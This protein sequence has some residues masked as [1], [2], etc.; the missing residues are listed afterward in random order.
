MHAAVADCHQCNRWTRNRSR[1]AMH[2]FGKQFDGQAAAND[3]INNH[4]EI[5]NRRVVIRRD[6]DML[7]SGTLAR[8]ASNLALAIGTT[9]SSE[10][11][12]I[13]VRSGC[14][15]GKCNNSGLDFVDKVTQ[16]LTGES[17]VGQLLSH[18]GRVFLAIDEDAV[19]VA[20]GKGDE[21]IF[22]RIVQ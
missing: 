18:L 10:P 19:K 4:R 15:R 21:N 11:E 12:N 8:S 14:K 16:F 13:H 20:A 9:R 3:L 1:L 22:K 17:R 6:N 2:F 5:G 7:R